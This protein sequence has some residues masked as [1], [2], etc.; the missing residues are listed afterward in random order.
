MGKKIMLLTALDGKYGTSSDDSWK[1]TEIVSSLRVARN[2]IQFMLF[3]FNNGD[4]RRFS[5]NNKISLRA[6]CKLMFDLEVLLLS[7]SLI[8]LLDRQ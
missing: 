3:T 7:I 1:P 4:V 6:L 8:F 2:S 5:I